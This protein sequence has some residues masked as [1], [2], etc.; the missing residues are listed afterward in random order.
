M[1]IKKDINDMLGSVY[2]QNSKIIDFDDGI[3]LQ[4]KKLKKRIE[5]IR[6]K[7][8]KAASELEFEKVVA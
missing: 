6:K 1:I 4:G 2:E 5:E 7:M 3:I 8:F